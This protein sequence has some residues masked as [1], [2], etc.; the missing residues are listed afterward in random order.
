M[1]IRALGACEIDTFSIDL[2]KL[3]KACLA[4]SFSEISVD[5]VATEK[6]KKMREYLSSGQAHVFIAEETGKLFGFLWGY[7]FLSGFEE[8]FH[9]AYIAVDPRRRQEGIGK[10][11]I[12]AAE[13][14]AR[15]MSL[16][17]IELTVAEDNI[18]A[19]EFYDKISFHTERRIMVKMCNDDKKEIGEE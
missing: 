6:L 2:Y 16:S 5:D 8:R 18:S 3:M 14:E 7:R 10:A 19:R 4:S 11:L 1:E 12:K 17:K 9:V 13:N 15:R